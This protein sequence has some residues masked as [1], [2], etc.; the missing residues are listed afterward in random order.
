MDDLD[1]FIA[2]LPK[3]RKSRIDPFLDRLIE[4]KRRGL[5]IRDMHEYLK[6]HD[7]DVHYETLRDFLHRN[8]VVS[9]KNKI[10]SEA[11]AER[12]EKANIQQEVDT[13]EFTP[14]NE[15]LEDEHPSMIVSRAEREK[16]SSRYMQNTNPILMELEKKK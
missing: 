10:N 5:N 1:T 4:M 16:K 15:V 9:K 11:K 2:S 7:V 6:L 12:T 8:K 3:R 14:S 13:P